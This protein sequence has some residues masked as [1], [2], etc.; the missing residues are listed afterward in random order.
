MPSLSM[1]PTPEKSPLTQAGREFIAH[2]PLEPSVSDDMDGPAFLTREMTLDEVKTQVRTF[3]NRVPGAVGAD[4]HLGGGF[5]QSPRHVGALLEVIAEAGLYFLDQRTSEAYHSA[6]GE[7]S[8]FVRTRTHRIKQPAAVEA[9]R[10]VEVALVLEGQALVI[11]SLANRH[12][13]A[14]GLA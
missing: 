6:T 10:A 13:G 3:L 5:T 9:K 12:R 14:Q 7:H 1:S 8:A 4:G 2:L 11:G